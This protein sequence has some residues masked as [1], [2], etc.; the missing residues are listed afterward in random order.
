MSDLHYVWRMG[1]RYA[2][3]CSWA[4]TALSLFANS[5]TTKIN[6]VLDNALNPVLHPSQFSQTLNI[7]LTIISKHSWVKSAGGDRI[8]NYDPLYPKSCHNV[9][10]IEKNYINLG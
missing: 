2:R 7:L 9:P 4:L 6:S 8:Q 3:I 1:N 10:K 5:I